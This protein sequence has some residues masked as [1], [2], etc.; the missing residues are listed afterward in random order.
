[1]SL[2][3]L[4]IAR[5]GFRT[6]WSVN[7]ATGEYSSAFPS[8]TGI[9]SD[10]ALTSHG[11]E[12][13]L[14]LAD[15]LGSIEPPIEAVFSS[16][17][18]RCL[19]TISPFVS[20]HG[21]KDGQA[22]PS[23]QTVILGEYG[24]CEWYGAA[25]FVQPSPATPT[26][27]KSHFPAL[28][29]PSLEASAVRKPKATG[30]FPD[31]LYERVRAGLCAVV[32]YCDARQIR[33]AVLCSHAAS[34]IVM[35]RVLTGDIPEDISREDFHAYT[36]GLSTYRRRPQQ[37]STDGN[38]TLDLQTAPG[39]SLWTCEAD[40]DCSHLSGGEERGWLFSGDEVFEGAVKQQDDSTRSRL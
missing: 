8:P 35:G 34:V 20:G 12:Q 6:T 23:G 28:D 2:E 27:M 29:L 37:P 19:Q 13:S 26:V 15:R 9:P 21:H 16:P 24:L 14:E 7:A 3:I 22:R 33:A 5:H 38:D 25:P 11:V 32:D 39:R 30:E 10:P 36:C 17:W 1:M 18:Y 40:M 31:E 4:Y